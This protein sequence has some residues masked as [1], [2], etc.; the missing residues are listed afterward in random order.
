MNRM[1]RT[2]WI[3]SFEAHLRAEGKE[4]STVRLY[5]AEA[6]ELLEKL[7]EQGKSLHQVDADDLLAIRSQLIAKGMKLSTINK[8]MS[9]V[10]SFFRWA[11]REGHALSGIAEGL[12]LEGAAKADKSELR[13]LSAEE[14]RQLLTVVGSEAQDPKSLRNEALV[15]AMLYAGLRVEEV[16]YLRLHSLQPQRLS[17]YD[18]SWETR[19]VPLDDHAYIP[20]LKWR[21]H[22]KA[23]GKSKHLE[24]DFL[25]VTERSGFMQPR[26]V[27]FVI[28]SLSEK[29]G[30]TVTCSMLRH[31]FCR[32]LA[33]QG[34]SAERIRDWAGHKSLLTTIQ[35]FE[36]GTDERT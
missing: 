14:E 28:E 12:R 13:W 6:E 24:S 34:A 27:Q 1:E 31:T 32:R 8:R 26:A 2:L 23:L 7:W 10:R 35:Y 5:R 15:A 22:R 17:V 19:A 20:L 4:E 11:A 25:F 36:K 29:A 30:F 33:E 16:S 21:R 3:S 18:E 9:V